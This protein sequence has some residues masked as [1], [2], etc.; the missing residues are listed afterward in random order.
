MVDKLHVAIEK[1]A[2]SQ[3]F[4]TLLKSRVAP[5][6]F[7]ERLFGIEYEA[8]P[9]DEEE[10][11][12]ELDEKLRKVF[13]KTVLRG[14]PKETTADTVLGG[15]HLDF[16]PSKQRTARVDPEALSRLTKAFATSYKTPVSKAG[17]RTVLVDAAFKPTAV[18]RGGK[19]YA[20]ANSF[21]GDKLD[22]GRIFDEAMK[23]AQYI[24]DYKPV[25]FK[26]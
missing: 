15:I 3:T 23:H 12:G 5:P 10:L 17:E 2:K 9:L 16:V 4:G 1:V 24:L 13:T 6:S 19:I 21:S 20:P 25:E 18:V 14:V 7:L 22:K 26:F 8:D 11:K